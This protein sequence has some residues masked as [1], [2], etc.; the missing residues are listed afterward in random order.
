MNAPYFVTK[1][2]GLIK[3]RCRLLSRLTLLHNLNSFPKY[4]AAKQQQITDLNRNLFEHYIIN[5]TRSTKARLRHNSKKVTFLYAK[6]ISF[7]FLP[8][9]FIRLLIVCKVHTYLISLYSLLFVLL[10]ISFFNYFVVA[11]IPYL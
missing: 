3:C 9:T 6:T 2:A 5:T 10:F 11:L 4:V 1:S 8:K 7:L